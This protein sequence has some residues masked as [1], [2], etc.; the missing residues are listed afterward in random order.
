MKRDLIKMSYETYLNRYL[1]A[2]NERNVSKQVIANRKSTIKKFFD[3]LCKYPNKPR[4]EEINRSY[5]EGFIMEMEETQSV[6][7]VNRY[8]RFLKS[9]FQYYKKENENNNQIFDYWKYGRD[10]QKN[11][12]LYDDNEMLELQ[13]V[14]KSN[15]NKFKSMR[16]ELMFLI[17]AYTGCSLDEVMRLNIYRN[18]NSLIDDENYILL[19]KKKIFFQ[20]EDGNVREIF[21]CEELLQKIN[22]YIKYLEVSKGYDLSNCPF[23]F[24]SIRSNKNYQRMG[25]STFQKSFREI[26]KHSNMFKDKQVSIKNVRHTFIK[27]LINKKISLEIIGDI[28]GL[29]I[30]T[31]K[32]YIDMEEI[33][34]KKD[35]I[36]KYNHPFNKMFDIR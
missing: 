2:L 29:D 9:F 24:P 5:V 15:K 18:S 35:D 13:R 22:T 12:T 32:W 16:D 20:N 33:T 19:D 27:N 6:A 36:L 31:L 30:S 10:V 28:T 26:K 21:L 17:L 8:F 25:R 23:M 1:N 4:F 11:F 3:F 34:T 14:L 7:T